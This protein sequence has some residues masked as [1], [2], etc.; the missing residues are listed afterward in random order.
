M[1]SSESGTHAI[2]RREALNYVEFI[3]QYCRPRRPVILTG[4]ISAWPAATRWTPAYFA[5]RVGDRR[6]EIDGGSY[7]V[8]QLVG[9]LDGSTPDAPAPYLR[10]QTVVDLFPALAGDLEP[11][12]VYAQPNWAE[13]PLLPP[14]IRRSRLHEILIGGRGAGF[15]VLHYDKDHLHAFISQLH[16]TKEF[17]VYAP[18]EEVFLY[19]KEALPNQSRVDMF[20]PDLE[21]YPEFT[22]ARQVRATLH[23]GDTVFMPAGWWHTT[24]MAG[25]SIS[26]TWNVVNRTNWADVIADTQRRVRQTSNAPLAAMFGLYARGFA[27]AKIAQERRSSGT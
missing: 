20:N 21:R 24:R 9:M 5:E 10:A 8:A 17:F 26:V 12:V 2:E 3:E 7:T 6:V 16:G 15:H 11:P 14:Q 4:A 22:K 23:P 1:R 13:S 18:E 19:P 27:R 25:P